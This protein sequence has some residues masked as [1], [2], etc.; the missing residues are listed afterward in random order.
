[1]LTVNGLTGM[2]LKYYDSTG[3]LT[4]IAAGQLLINVSY[5]LESDGTGWVVVT[6]LI[7]A[8]ASTVNTAGSDVFAYLNFS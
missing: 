2:A 3:T 4:S 7:L 1:V 8:P 6:G 5:D